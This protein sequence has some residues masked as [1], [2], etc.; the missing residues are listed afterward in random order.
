MTRRYQTNGS[1]AQ[2]FLTLETTV[3]AYVFAWLSAFKIDF[4]TE[5][6]PI[7]K[8]DPSVLACDGTHT[9]VSVKNLDCQHPVTEPEIQEVVKPLHKRAQRVLVYEQT[10]RMAPEIY[11]TKNTWKTES[12]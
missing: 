11:Y 9:G 8:H 3:S 6:D 2:P 7:C 10:A 4:R 5:I 12:G 1:G